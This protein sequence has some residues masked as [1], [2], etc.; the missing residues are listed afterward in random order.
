MCP[1]TIYRTCPNLREVILHWS[2][3]N[4]VLRGWSEPEGLTRLPKLK[5]LELK[6]PKVCRHPKPH[7]SVIV[8]D[9][10]DPYT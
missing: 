5:R 1:F 9:S 8:L 2:G 10:E 6:R 7:F 3:S 4:A